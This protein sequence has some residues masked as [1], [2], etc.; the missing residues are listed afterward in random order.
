MSNKTDVK[1]VLEGVKKAN[2]LRSSKKEIATLSLS[3]SGQ[4]IY[5][6]TSE[7]LGKFGINIID[8]TGDMKN[9]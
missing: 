9:G 6:I 2:K 4:K 7:Q 8:N 1:I 3:E 5:L